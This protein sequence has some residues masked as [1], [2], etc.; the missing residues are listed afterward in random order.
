MSIQSLDATT[1]RLTWQ[2]SAQAAGYR[3]WVRNA[4][5]GGPFT[6]DQSSTDTNSHEIAFLFPGN[7]NF[8]FCVSA[9][10]GALESDR[11][12]CVSVPLPPPSAGLAGRSAAAGRSP[13]PVEQS[14][15]LEGR[16]ADP[17]RDLVAA[18]TGR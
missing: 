3:V 6:A 10:N 12:G 11:S 17:G 1:V 8:E 7:W 14:P 5:T 13:D 18:A 2:G 4:T 15:L 16:F 9:F